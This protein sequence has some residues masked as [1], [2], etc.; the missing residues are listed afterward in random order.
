MED[1][2]LHLLAGKR[3]AVAFVSVFS[4]TQQENPFLQTGKL[5]AKLQRKATPGV[6]C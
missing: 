4:P 3:K 2:A 1:R 6:Q 5:T